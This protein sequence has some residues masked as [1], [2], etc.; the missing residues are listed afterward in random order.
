MCLPDQLS[1]KSFYSIKE[2][3]VK[4]WII[5]LLMATLCTEFQSNLNT[6][7]KLKW[8]KSLIRS[9]PCLVAHY[10]S[11]NCAHTQPCTRFLTHIQGCVT[12]S[13]IR[14][15]APW[16]P[17]LFRGGPK[18]STTT[19]FRQRHSVF[20]PPSGL[21]SQPDIELR[22]MIDCRVKALLDIRHNQI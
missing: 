6:H 21:G 17:P 4:Q 10:R 11:K 9:M 16:R 14:P 18:A 5:A 7:S 12:G 8:V 19:P 22:Q 20:P 1:I 3:K 13:K 2:N 15:V